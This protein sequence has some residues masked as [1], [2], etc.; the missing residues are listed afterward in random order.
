MFTD[1]FQDPGEHCRIFLSLSTMKMA[2]YI[3][4]SIIPILVSIKKHPRPEGKSS[5]F[6]PNTGHSS[7]VKKSLK[8]INVDGM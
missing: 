7:S 4:A 1:I 8:R 6:H 3:L 5:L 2:N